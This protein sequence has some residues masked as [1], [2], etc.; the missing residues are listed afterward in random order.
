MNDLNHVL[1]KR[2]GRSTL[3]TH[4]VKITEQTLDLANNIC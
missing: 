4:V 1:S 2:Q 3:Q